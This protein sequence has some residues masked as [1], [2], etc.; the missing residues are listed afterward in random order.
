MHIWFKSFKFHTFSKQHKKNN[1]LSQQLKMFAGL[2]Y[3]FS[4]SQ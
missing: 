1:D 3:A 4:L 2:E